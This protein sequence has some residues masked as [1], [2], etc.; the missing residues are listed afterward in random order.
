MI[1]RRLLMVDDDPQ[2]GTFVRTVA[3]SLGYETRITEDAEVFKATYRSFSPRVVILDLSLPGTDGIELLAFLAAER[4]R[5][6]ILLMSGFDARVRDAAQRLGEAR[7]LTM[8]GIVPKP[9][10][11]VELRSILES[12]TVE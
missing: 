9:V 6:H 11:V 10:R 5:A 2:I 4:H 8:A 12:L 3:E 1:A 7:G